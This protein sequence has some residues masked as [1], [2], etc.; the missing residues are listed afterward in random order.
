[1][2]Q[3]FAHHTGVTGFAHI[4]VMVPGDLEVPAPRDE[5]TVKGLVVLNVVSDNTLYMSDLLAVSVVEYLGPGPISD[6]VDF[7]QIRLENDQLLDVTVFNKVELIGR[8]NLGDIS[9]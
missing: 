9:V 8:V 3:D 7:R 2:S 1:M 6:V 5:P 4:A